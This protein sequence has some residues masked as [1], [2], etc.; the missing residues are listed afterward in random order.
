LTSRDTAHSLVRF[1]AGWW[2][3]VGLAT[4]AFGWQRVLTPGGTYFGSVLACAFVAA[5]LTLVRAGM[6]VA[7]TGMACLFALLEFASHWHAGLGRALAALAAYAIVGAG[8]L[9]VAI[10]FDLLARSRVRIGKFLLM[11]PLLGGVYL[12]AAPAATLFHDIPGGATRALL[13]SVFSGI[14]VGDGVGLGVELV[15]LFMDA[16]ASRGATAEETR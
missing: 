12:A 14:V 13:L 8:T 16:G 10:L 3:G 9:L 5:I 15:E 6:P 4:V 11:G 7:A 1:V 2:G